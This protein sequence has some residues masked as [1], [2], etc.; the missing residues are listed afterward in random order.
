MTGQRLH[1]KGLFYG[2]VACLALVILAVLL[3]PYAITH[4]VT[5]TVW[6]IGLS[7]VVLLVMLITAW[8]TRPDQLD[9]ATY[10]RSDAGR[11]QWQQRNDEWMTDKPQGEQKS[12]KS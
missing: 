7:V 11:Q 10:R 2:L 4:G 9:D 5:Q 6:L 12:E 1:R 3:H 8:F